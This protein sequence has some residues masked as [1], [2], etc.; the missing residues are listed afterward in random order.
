[1]SI[2]PTRLCCVAAIF[3]SSPSQSGN[4]IAVQVPGTWM[5]KHVHSPHHYGRRLSG[6]GNYIKHVNRTR[7]QCDQRVTTVFSAFPTNGCIFYAFS[8][9]F[10]GNICGYTLLLFQPRHFH[11][12]FEDF[13][14]LLPVLAGTTFACNLQ[15]SL[16]CFPLTFYTCCK[17]LCSRG[18]FG[19]YSTGRILQGG[20]PAYQTRR[21]ITLLYPGDAP[22]DTNIAITAKKFLATHAQITAAFPTNQCGDRRPMRGNRRVRTVPGCANTA[23]RRTMYQH[24]SWTCQHG[25]WTCQ[26]GA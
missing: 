23:N 18:G 5:D 14:M 24:G 22:N 7:Q 12:F 8:T 13:H 15:D 4:F 1:M 17:I 6:H 10:L 26:Q 21:L 19:V 2:H 3:L 16:A 20:P 11:D 9:R 25:R